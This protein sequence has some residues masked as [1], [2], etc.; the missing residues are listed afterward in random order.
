[1]FN[2]QR[3][4]S[5][6]REMGIPGLKSQSHIV[7]IDPTGDVRS[8]KTGAAVFRCWLGVARAF[9]YG[10]SRGTRCTLPN[11]SQRTM[12]TVLLILFANQPNEPQRNPNGL[13]NQRGLRSRPRFDL[14][15][16]DWGLLSRPRRVRA[17][18]LRSPRWVDIPTRRQG[19]DCPP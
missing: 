19:V 9:A 16:A 17:C 2:M 3:D 7:A 4:N 12:R 1:M 18:R 10:R 5:R 6:A 13:A 11:L 15:Y 8:P 14:G